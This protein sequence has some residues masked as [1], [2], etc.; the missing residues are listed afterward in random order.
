MSNIDL[1]ILES[2]ISPFL[3]TLSKINNATISLIGT[4]SQA[5]IDASNAALD[6]EIEAEKAKESF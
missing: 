1:S 3:E 4:R 5:S 6:A 2:S